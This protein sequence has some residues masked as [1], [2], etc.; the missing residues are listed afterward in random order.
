MK[1]ISTQIF[2]IFKLKQMYLNWQYVIFRI[3]SLIFFSWSDMLS[4]LFYLE[5]FDIIMRI[6]IYSLCR[7]KYISSELFSCSVVVVN[8]LWFQ[9]CVFAFTHSLCLSAFPRLTIQI[10]NVGRNFQKQS[11]TRR[12]N[13]VSMINFGLTKQL[14]RLIGIISSS[15]YCK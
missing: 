9:V 7:Y 10:L 4:F 14:K 2:Y 12:N 1:E 5:L 11:T 13:T 15:F 8:C 6:H 3:S